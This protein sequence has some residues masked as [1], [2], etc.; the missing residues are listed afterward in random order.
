MLQELTST[1]V[2]IDPVAGFL[3]QG[4]GAEVVTV[5]KLGHGAGPSAHTPW[6]QPASWKKPRSEQG[7]PCIWILTK[8]N[9][10]EQLSVFLKV[11]LV[12]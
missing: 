1:S 6:W 9:D 2:L 12:K 4:F 3:V 7:E 11:F 5:A 10:L 8:M